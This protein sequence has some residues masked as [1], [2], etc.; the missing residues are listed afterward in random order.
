MSAAGDARFSGARVVGGYWTKDN[1]VEIDLVGADRDEPGDKLRL[2]FIGTIKWRSR[3][4]LD[5]SDIADLEK[6]T[7]RMTGAGLATPVVAVSRCGFERIARPFVGISA[8]EILE[9]F[10]AD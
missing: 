10:P 9:A 8:E 4:P 6:A 1:Q 5:G 2:A 7:S 3:K